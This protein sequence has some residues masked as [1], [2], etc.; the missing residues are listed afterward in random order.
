MGK[1]V[2][3]RIMSQS[4]D[5]QQINRAMR[6]MVLDEK[7]Y[8]T[9]GINL[10]TGEACRLGQRI[11][12]DVSQEGA[13]LVNLYFGAEMKLE[14]NNNAFVGDKPAVGSLMLGREMLKEVAVF[15]VMVKGAIAVVEPDAKTGHRAIAVF[16]PDLLNM[17]TRHNA[18]VFNGAKQEGYDTADVYTNPQAK[19]KYF[20]RLYGLKLNPLAESKIALKKDRQPTF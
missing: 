13:E 10:L 12:C 11:L 3:V 19:S 20:E 2:E 17:Y 1:L 18:E 8:Q 14:K 4:N 15:G 9:L 16:D 7:G 5:S 6:S